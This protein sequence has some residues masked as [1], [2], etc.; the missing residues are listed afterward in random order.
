MPV[1]NKV[2]T[3][4]IDDVYHYLESR[5]IPFETYKLN[6][7]INMSGCFDDKDISEEANL[8]IDFITGVR[9]FTKSSV[10]IKN[11]IKE[12]TLEKMRSMVQDSTT[13]GEDV[14]I[15]P[16]HAICIYR[17]PTVK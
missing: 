3:L 11:K 2:H 12:I 8:L 13:S 15:I 16:D 14:I 10:T 7:S 1:M 5:G 6:M 4:P 9:E 17:P